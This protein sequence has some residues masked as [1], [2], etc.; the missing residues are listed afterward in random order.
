MPAGQP[1]APAAARPEATPAGRNRPAAQK[2]DEQALRQLIAAF[3]DAYNA[4]NAKALA[5]M[6][7]VDGEIVDQNGDTTHGRADIEQLFAAE[8]EDHPHAKIE[9]IVESIRFLSPIAAVEEG[10]STITHEPGEPGESGHY[11]VVYV[12]QDGKWQIASDRDLPDDE[13]TSKSELDQLGWLVG[14]WV[15]ESPEGLVKTSYQWAENH[16]FLLG[17]FTVQIAGKPRSPARNASAGIRWQKKFALG[18][19]IPRE[20]SA[21]ATGPARISSGSSS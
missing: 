7:T 9:D 5:A 16:H 17:E 13:A 11:A 4:G 1:T 14:S 15:D 20:A 12:K 10:I 3:T 21:R 8:F 19:S 2:A 18:F 6:F